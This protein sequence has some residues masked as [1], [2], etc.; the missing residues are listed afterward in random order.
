MKIVISDKIKKDIFTE[1]DED[2]ENE[3][4]DED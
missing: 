2:E 4:N 3:E 1:N